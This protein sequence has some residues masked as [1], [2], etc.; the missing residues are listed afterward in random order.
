MHSTLKSA[1]PAFVFPAVGRNL[2]PSHL[3]AAAAPGA[4][5][6]RGEGVLGA[7]RSCGGPEP[8]TRP[9]ISWADPAGTLGRRRA[10]SGCGGGG[11]AGPGLR[12]GLGGAAPPRAALFLRQLPRSPARRAE[13]CPSVPAGAASRR[14]AMT[15][16]QIVL[17]GPGPWGF[18]LVGGKDFEQ[19][20][21]ISR[22]RAAWARAERTWGLGRSRRRRFGS[23]AG[24]GA[25]GRGQVRRARGSRLP[26]LRSPAS[27][28][29][30]A[31]TRPRGRRGAGCPRRGRALSTR[32]G[33][34][35]PGSPH[36]G[37]SQRGSSK[38]QRGGE[39]QEHRGGRR[40]GRGFPG[41][42]RD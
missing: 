36:A 33:R 3:A 8:Q 25:A 42:G 2:L 39:Q 9:G 17:Q 15:T 14:R 7:G 24:A 11:R 5:A 16:Q 13:S 27:R 40:G 30:G 35:A 1:Q 20:L 12:R 18:R 28:R 21:A 41:D 4:G 22:V 10:G 26:T 31:P 37:R 23:R 38:A 6:G 19:P 32:Q 34:G 29:R